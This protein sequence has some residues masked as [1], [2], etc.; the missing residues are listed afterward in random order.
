MP[1]RITA[2]AAAL[3]LAGCASTS[4]TETTDPILSPDGN[5]A[6]RR[7]LLL[8]DLSVGSL[9]NGRAIDETFELSTTTFRTAADPNGG[10][11]AGLVRGTASREGFSAGN[12]MRYVAGQNLFIFDIDTEAGVFSEQLQLLLLED[13]VD[14]PGL[15][16]SQIAKLLF[17]EANGF[18]V[19]LGLP[20]GA[21]I[22]EIANRLTA[23]QE[24]DNEAD[25][26]FYESIADAAQTL[27]GFDQYIFGVPNGYYEAT[28]TNGTDDSRTDTVAI[29]S[30]EQTQA[31]GSTLH[32]HL[33]FGHRTPLPEMPTSGGAEYRGKVV[34]SVL[35]NN[36]VRSLT[37]D[38][39]VDVNFSTGL[40]DFAINTIIRE[41]GGQD[42]TTTFIPY[43]SLIGQGSIT[44][45]E[46]AGTLTEPSGDSTGDFSGGF[47]G[48]V[49][50]ELGGTFS[51]G[52]SASFATG[53]FTGRQT[54][55]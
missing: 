47:F 5:V 3:V 29:G 35:T 12:T 11:T 34:G 16:N 42:G 20:P 45:T 49:A 21:S 51:F 17:A 19:D 52:N 15:P 43:K 50:N 40:L 48:P 22:A 14:T 18:S 25:N 31:D 8:S 36:A 38:V 44:D 24:S 37:G 41:G 55:E 28:N 33:V 27:L 39:D 53:A 23:L 2:L 7:N 9:G 13:P 6:P 10:P 46:F 4:G 1:A 32:G 30:F 26:E 54:Q